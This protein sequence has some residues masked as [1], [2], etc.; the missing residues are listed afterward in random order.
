[1]TG[2][3]R[4][5]KSSR[6]VLGKRTTP[7][8]AARNITRAC[9]VSGV[10]RLPLTTKPECKLDS[11]G[12]WEA[13]V[14]QLWQ[15]PD[16]QKQPF[17]FAIEGLYAC[18]RPRVERQSM[19]EGHF[20]LRADREYE[21]RV[22]HWHPDADSLPSLIRGT[23]MTAAVESPQLRPITSPRLAI[24]SP[25]DVKAY[26]VRT[27][28]STKEEFASFVVKIEGAD[29]KPM[30][31]QPEIFLPVRIR[32]SYFRIGSLTVVLAGLLWLQQLVPL[33]SKGPVDKLVAW[34]TLLVSA[35]AAFVVVFGI[36]KPLS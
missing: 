7:T 30:A 2:S 17:F 21:L 28:A 22:L 26:R 29:G 10:S 34:V 4:K 33:L 19:S 9:R 15:S 6:F 8:G 27:G 31:D 24:D 1:M 11:I 23:T 12:M 14:K 36:K 32:P 20:N 18:T 25:Y 35:I 5:R 3:R 16:F 13:A